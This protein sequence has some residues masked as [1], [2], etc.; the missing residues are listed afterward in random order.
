MTRT[1]NTQREVE[2]DA[3][4]PATLARVPQVGIAT[5]TICLFCPMPSSSRHYYGPYYP[6][7]R[8]VVIIEL[9]PLDRLRACDIAQFCSHSGAHRVHHR[10]H[11][12]LLVN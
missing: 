5:V 1:R 2:P 9:V 11:L 3:R 7:S 12:S 10:S 4:A 6:L 8:A